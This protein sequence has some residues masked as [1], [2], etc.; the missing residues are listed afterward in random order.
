[1]SSALYPRC[2]PVLPRH[3]Y[4]CSQ[5]PTFLQ[6]NLARPQTRK[7]FLIP[8][9]IFVLQ[10]LVLPKSSMTI[11]GPCAVPQNTLLQAASTAAPVAATAALGASSTSHHTRPRGAR[12]PPSLRS[13]SLPRYPHP[14]CSHSPLPEIGLLHLGVCRPSIAVPLDSTSRVPQHLHYFLIPST[15]AHS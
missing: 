10:I 2:H 12:A 7:S 14:S 6:H 1:M 11:H 5:V 8:M 15:T 13:T 9:A 3:Y 4:P